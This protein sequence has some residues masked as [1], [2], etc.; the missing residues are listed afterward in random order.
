MVINWTICSYHPD[1]G[2]IIM[3]MPRVPAATRE[4]V[5]NQETKNPTQ[6]RSSKWF[7]DWIVSSNNSIYHLGRQKKGKDYWNQWVDW[8]IESYAGTSKAIWMCI[9]IFWGILRKYARAE[10]VTVPP[11][12]EICPSGGSNS[13]A[14][15]AHNLT[16][17]RE[18]W[19]NGSKAWL[20]LERKERMILST[21]T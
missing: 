2:S 16:Q 10:G 11:S 17:F 20:D 4:C 13:P 15:G 21:R 3:V 14:F 5:K 19:K 6:I 8:F 1:Q 12:E 9:C 7:C 18:K